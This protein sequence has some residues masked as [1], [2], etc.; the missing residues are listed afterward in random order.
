VFAIV[1]NPLPL[2]EMDLPWYDPRAQEGKGKDAG[3][4]LPDWEHLEKFLDELPDPDRPGLFDPLLPVAERA[5]KE[6][7]YL[8]FGWWRLFF[9]RPWGLRGME[10]LM[11]DYYIHP[12]EVHRLHEG[13]SRLYCGMIRRAAREL[14]PDG[15]W[16]SD[17]LGTQRSLMMS[18]EH[19]RTLIKPYFAQVGQAARDGGMHWWLHSC[20]DN[21]Q[22]MDD[23]IEAGVNVFHPVQKHTMDFRDTAERFGDRMTFLAGI[24]VQHTLQEAGPEGVRAEVREMIDIFDRPDG[25]L[26]LA[27]GNGIVP[28]TPLENVDAFLDETLRYGR[29]HRR[30]WGA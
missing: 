18:P 25:G 28:P 5:H 12:E 26:C 17:D 8:M 29:E 27:A 13:L 23:L 22:V 11:V 24:D 4:V 30:K 21:S 20:G 10:N 16:T 1:A 3:G 2:W 14:E 7:R 6:G 19:F 15:F 9:E